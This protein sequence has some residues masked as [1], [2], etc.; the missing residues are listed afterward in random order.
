MPVD[1]GHCQFLEI[2]DTCQAHWGSALSRLQLQGQGPRGLADI[3]WGFLELCCPRGSHSHP[4]A[5]LHLNL[6]MKR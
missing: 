2:R 1:T 3:K 5:Y 4:C 6:R